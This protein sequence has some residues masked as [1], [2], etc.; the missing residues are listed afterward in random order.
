MVGC[1]GGQE[2]YTA[3]MLMQ[4]LAAEVGAAEQVRPRVFATDIDPELLTE[5]RRG[6]YTPE[7]V[8]ALSPERLARFFVTDAGGYRVQ[9]SVR[10]CV[11]F[12]QHDTF[13]GPPITRLSLVTC[14]NLLVYL[15][16]LLQR[17]MLDTFAGA[18]LPGGLLLL[19]PA[20]QVSLS[21]DSEGPL[22]NVRCGAAPDP[23]PQPG[24]LPFE[25]LERRWQIYRR[26]DASAPLRPPRRQP[27]MAQL[28]AMLQATLQ[29][30]WTPPAA[31]LDAR[32]HLLERTVNL[33]AYLAPDAQDL[34]GFPPQWQPL[35]RDLLS[36]A[37][38]SG[39]AGGGW[40]EATPDQ[41]RLWLNVEPL[42]EVADS[43]LLVLAPTPPLAN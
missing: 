3:A 32:G 40:A 10:D 8:S 31:V 16:P 22:T 25:V 37:Q 11:S 33:S 29:R 43:W 27:N 6:W 21:P 39:R 5:A 42:P 41:P 26:T 7:T 24:E 34:S 20:E 28:Q 1:S 13:G 4:E 23:E 38:V 15:S 2:A 35:L 12:V 17:R 19:S 36:G 9:Q 14:R 18:L 30:S